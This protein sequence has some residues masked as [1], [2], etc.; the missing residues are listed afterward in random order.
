V[1]RVVVVGGGALL[2]AEL[3]CCMMEGLLEGG[4]LEREVEILLLVVCEEELCGF[5]AGTIGKL[6][7]VCEEEGCGFVAGMFGKLLDGGEL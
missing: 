7:V 1:I 2:G 5:V 6:L 3:D 4:G